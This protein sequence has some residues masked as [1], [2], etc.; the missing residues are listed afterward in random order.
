MLPLSLLYP[1]NFPCF[2]RFWTCVSAWAKKEVFF[3]TRIWFL[4]TAEETSFFLTSRSSRLS[5]ASASFLESRLLSRTE[6]GCD[7]LIFLFFA[8][9]NVSWIWCPTCTYEDFLSLVM[10]T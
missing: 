7:F 5:S 6:F 4:T 2:L 8:S 9:Q 3:E 10:R 1:L